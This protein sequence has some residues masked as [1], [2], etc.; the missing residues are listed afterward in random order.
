MLS[1][2]MSLNF[3]G[4]FEAFVA[5]NA[6]VGDH[7]DLRGPGGEGSLQDVHAGAAQSDSLHHHH[8]GASQLLLR[9]RLP[10][11][12]RGG[13]CHRLVVELRPIKETEECPCGVLDIVEIHQVSDQLLPT[14][15]TVQPH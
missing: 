4:G 1:Q 6:L 3:L 8:A 10:H 2:E 5:D 15:T 14:I 12:V 7:L 13:V 9:L 11:N